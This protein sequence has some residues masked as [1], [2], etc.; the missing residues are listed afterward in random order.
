MTQSILLLKYSEE[1]RALDQGKAVFSSVVT[2]EYTN[3]VHVFKYSVRGCS[4]LCGKCADCTS[5]PMMCRMKDRLKKSPWSNELETTL[6]LRCKAPVASFSVSFVSKDLVCLRKLGVP[7]YGCCYLY[8]NVDE[9]VLVDCLSVHMQRL[10]SHTAL[11]KWGTDTPYEETP[12]LRQDLDRHFTVVRAI[13][14]IPIEDGQMDERC[15][16]V[17]SKV[18]MV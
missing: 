16:E 10:N 8:D 7:V 5:V 1:M 15:R 12:L 3:S 9:G 14:L 6:R 4:D 13:D 11:V 17:C 2:Q 18:Y